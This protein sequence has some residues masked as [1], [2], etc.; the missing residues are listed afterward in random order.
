MI[1]L[2]RRINCVLRLFTRQTKRTNLHDFDLGSTQT[3]STFLCPT[4]GQE[5]SLTMKGL[6]SKVHHWSSV[7][8]RASQIFKHIVVKSLACMVCSQCYPLPLSNGFLIS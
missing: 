3:L 6:M 7:D 8:G 1:Q 2:I 4:T 5:S